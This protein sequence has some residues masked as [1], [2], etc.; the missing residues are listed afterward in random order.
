MP[1]DTSVVS[2]YTLN[3]TRRVLMTSHSIGMESFSTSPTGLMVL[4]TSL[5]A[6]FVSRKHSCRHSMSLV[7]RGHTGTT[8]IIQLNIV[9][10]FEDH[11]LYMILRTL[12]HIYTISMMVS[13]HR[14]Y[15]HALS[16]NPNRK[17]RY[18]A[19]RLVSISCQT[20]RFY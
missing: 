12:W 9:M 19:L 6:R 20:E 14:F 16:R 8:H 7:R 1:L 4:H 2:T 3:C 11:W 10:D 5:S 18:H 13:F 17:H 15:V